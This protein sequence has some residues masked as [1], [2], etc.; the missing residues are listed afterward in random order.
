MVH[1]PR[2]KI[3]VNLKAL[4]CL[5]DLPL[6]ICS[7]CP[8]GGCTDHGRTRQGIH[9]QTVQP[10]PVFPYSPRVSTF[11]HAFFRSLCPYFLHNRKEQVM[12]CLP[13]TQ[14]REHSLSHQNDGGGTSRNKNELP[15]RHCKSLAQPYVCMAGHGH[16]TCITRYCM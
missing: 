15:W 12:K 11:K 4:A 6:N 2:N 8:P 14:T 9:E 7:H 1:V 10:R 3:L 13:S 16:H 5:R